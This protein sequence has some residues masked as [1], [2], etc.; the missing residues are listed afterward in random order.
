V[1]S[2]QLLTKTTRSMSARS[3]RRVITESVL[4]N[5]QANVLID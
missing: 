4:N 5:A 1:D 2:N 3:S